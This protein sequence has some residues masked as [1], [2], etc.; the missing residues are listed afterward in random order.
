M[1]QNV[2]P[3]SAVVQLGKMQGAQLLDVRFGREEDT[4]SVSRKM[5]G[6]FSAN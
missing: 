3:K 4:L 5:R 6:Y 1:A 2:M